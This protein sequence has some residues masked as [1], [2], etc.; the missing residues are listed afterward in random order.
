MIPL[1]VAVVLKVA[2]KLNNRNFIGVEISEDY[3]QIA[4]RR[5]QEVKE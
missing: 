3:F 1:W 4:T 2:A 5:I